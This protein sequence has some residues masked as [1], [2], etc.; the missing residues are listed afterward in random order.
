VPERLPGRR[1]LPQNRSSLLN[2][3]RQGEHSKIRH[4]V[5]ILPVNE[6][7]TSGSASTSETAP[8]LII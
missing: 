2:F 4:V 3:D 5:L 1:L 6:E 8:L 7:I